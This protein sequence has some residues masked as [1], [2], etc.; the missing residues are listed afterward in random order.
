MFSSS[1]SP[2]SQ[3]HLHRY[4]HV[5]VAHKD[6]GEGLLLGTLHLPE[7]PLELARLQR[8]RHGVSGTRLNVLKPPGEAKN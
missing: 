4:L 1:P 2:S 6:P 5:R 3:V 7:G 8:H